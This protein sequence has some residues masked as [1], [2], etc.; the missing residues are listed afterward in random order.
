MPFIIPTAPTASILS[1]KIYQI[2]GYKMVPKASAKA[3]FRYQTCSLL[4]QK[5]S[6]EDVRVGPTPLHESFGRKPPRLQAVLVV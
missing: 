3:T 6:L 2:S 1:F 5:L 4:S